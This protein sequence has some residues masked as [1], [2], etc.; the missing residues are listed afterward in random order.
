MITLLICFVFRMFLCLF[1]GGAP[2]QLPSGLSALGANTHQTQAAFT[3]KRFAQIICKIRYHVK[4]HS[5]KLYLFENLI[6]LHSQNISIIM[7]SN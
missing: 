7:F 4:K 1:T 6:S 5:L 3:T 2:Q